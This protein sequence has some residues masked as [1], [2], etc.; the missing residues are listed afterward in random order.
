MTQ[1][2][3]L[4]TTTALGRPAVDL[5]DV[6]DLLARDPH[7]V[8]GRLLAEGPV[9]W[10]VQPDGT[11]TWLVLGYPEVKEAL[12]HPA[13]SSDAVNASPSWRLRYRGSA[14]ATQMPQGRVLVLT[15]PPEHTRLRKPVAKAFSSSRAR[16]LLPLIEKTT[17]RLVSRLPQASSFDAVEDFAA[18]LALTVICDVLGISDS[19]QVRMRSWTHRISFATRTEDAMAARREL[20]PYADQLISEKLACPGPDL[21]SALLR[22]VDAEL[23]SPTELRATL[24][25]LFNGGHE[26]SISLL[27]SALL[28]LLT[29][30]DQLAMLRADPTLIDQAID[31]TL[32]FEPPLTIPMYRFAR[33]DLTLGDG[34]VIPR[35]GSQVSIVLVSALRDPRA[36]PDPHT[37][38]IQ[39]P[40][41]ERLPFGHGIHFCPG[42]AL[43]RLEAAVGLPALLNRFPDLAL[44]A[45]PAT[46]DWH[47]GPPIRSLGGLPL[48]TRPLSIPSSAPSGG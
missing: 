8:Y 29:H 1:L 27:A 11:P 46:L 18:P 9:Q 13:L 30:P 38:D 2:P 47:P 32:R 22:T 21:M 44:A 39:R 43:A 48:L 42:W 10:A 5:R 14:D 25:A 34:F 16:D 37:F 17:E 26:T 6:G 40:A 45:D 15:D 12:S 31:E 20:I 24:I 23:L 36:F 3:P 19:D 33:C 41:G 7:T 28:C 4:T 35:D